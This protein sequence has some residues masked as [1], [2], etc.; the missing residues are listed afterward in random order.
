MKAILA[1]A[2]FG[3]PAAYCFL[4]AYRIQ[5]RWA[6]DGIVKQVRPFG[7]IRFWVM[8]GACFLVL[9]FVAFAAALDPN[10][11]KL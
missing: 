3:I 5:Q 4:R 8:A 9:G 6:V 10:F 11:L 1:A 7:A 2:L